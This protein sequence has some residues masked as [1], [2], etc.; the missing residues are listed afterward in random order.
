M[1]RVAASRLYYSV[2]LMPFTGPPPK[3]VVI[4]PAVTQKSVASL[5]SPGTTSVFKMQGLAGTITPTKTGRVLITISGTIDTWSAHTGAGIGYAIKYGTGTAP[6]NGDAT[7][8]TSL[9]LYQ[10]FV[11]PII[12]TSSSDVYTPFSIS[13][14]ATGLAVGTPYWIDLEATEYVDT[15]STELYQITLVAVE[16]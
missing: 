10:R 5:N 1:L 14:L 3:P 12:P 6:S 13:A 16:I 2:L 9:G 15:G 11:L 4:V 8:G 7:T